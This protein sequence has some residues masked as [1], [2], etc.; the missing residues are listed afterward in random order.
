MFGE[1][2]INHY[3]VLED[4]PAILRLALLSPDCALSQYLWTINR[5]TA[6]VVVVTVITLPTALLR[7]PFLAAAPVGH[8]LH[9]S[10]IPLSDMLPQPSY[11]ASG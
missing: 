4:L 10:F 3:L 5:A 1:Q 9:S 11:H 2:W 7:Q 6:G 8:L